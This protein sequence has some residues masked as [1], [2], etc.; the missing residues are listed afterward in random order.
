MTWR[1]YYY[2][3][4]ATSAGDRWRRASSW[5]DVTG[6][7]LPLARGGPC[8]HALGQVPAAEFRNKLLWVA[9]TYEAGFVWKKKKKLLRAARD[10]SSSQLVWLPG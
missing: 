5:M 9:R 1:R 8:G 10:S 6:R 3:P 4:G 2:L 7:E